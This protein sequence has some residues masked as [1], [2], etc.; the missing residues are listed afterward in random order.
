MLARARESAKPVHHLREG[1]TRMEWLLIVGLGVWVFLQSQSIATLKRNLATLER[2]VSELAPTPQPSTQPIPELLLTERVPVDSPPEPAPV[3]DEPLLLTQVVPPDDR[4]PLLLDT[5]LPDVSNDEDDT[6]K[7]LPPIA[8]PQRAAPPPRAAATKPDRR[9]EQWLAENGLA[10]LAGGAFALGAI[11]LVSFAAQQ[12]WFTP[13]VQIICAIALGL[14]LIGA[15]EWARRFSIAKP[16]GHPLAAALLAGAGVVALYVT[17]WASHGLYGYADATTALILLA[18]CAAILIGLSFLHG[19]ALGV[20]AVIMV[21]LAPALAG[22]VPWP[23]PALTLFVCTMAATGFGLAALRRWAWVA[24][25][26]L[27]GLYFWFASAIAEDEI[28]RALAVLSTASLGAALVALRQ[29]L[30]TTPE[31]RFSWD[32]LRSYAPSAAIAVSSVLLLWVWL[33]AVPLA[34]GRIAGPALIA[35]FHVALASYAVRA[36]LAH[37]WSLV[38]AIAASVLGVVFYLAAR[39]HF[40]PLGADVYPTIL[41]VSF[42]IVLCALTARP[43]RGGRVIVAGAGAIAAALLTALAAT[44]RLDWN[45]LAAWAPLI[46]GAMLLFAAAWRTEDEAQNVRKDAAIDL[47]AAAGVALALLAIESAV[48]GPARTAV[49]AGFALLLA[50]GHTWRGWRVLRPAALTAAAIAVAHTLSPALAGAS[51]SGAIPIWGALVIIGAAAALLFAAGYFLAEDEE[52]SPWSEAMTSAGVIAIIVGVFLLLRWIAAGGV[53]SGF[54]TLTEA[55]LRAVALMAAGHTLLPRA[56]QTLGPISRWRGH[57]FMGAG[58]LYAFAIAGIARNPWWGA[59]PAAVLGPPLLDTLTLAFAA[60]AALAFAASYRLYARDR[61]FARIYMGAGALMA[62]LWIALQLRRAFHGADMALGT[63]G[64]FEGACYGLLFLATALAIAAAARW[65]AAKNGDGALAL[66]LSRVMRIAAWGGVII[67]G[68]TLLLTRHPIWGLHDFSATDALETG[69]ATLTQAAALVLTL[70]L[71]RMLSVSREL[72]PARFAA[73]TASAL[74]AWSFGHSA[75][76]WIAQRGE[77]DNA[78]P[79]A[80]LEGF[81]HTLWPLTLIVGAAQLT[82]RAPG[83]DSVR[84]Y[85]NDLQ[86]IWATAIWPALLY[87]AYGLWLYFNP[88]RGAEAPSIA[89]PLALVVMLIVFAIAAGLS[90]AALRVPHARWSTQLRHAAIIGAIGHILIGATM[91]VRWLFHGADMSSAPAIDTEMWSYSATWAILGAA[92]FGLGMQRSEALLRWTGLSILIGT[93]VFV[94]YLTLTRLT[95]VAQFGSMLGLAV[96]LMGVA[97]LA[98]TY[99]PKNDPG[100]LLTITPSAR[101][102]RRRGRRQRTP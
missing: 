50:V 25:V 6:A 24:A 15:S 32:Q 55:S 10:W 1:G 45:A 94:F 98:R 52:R 41:A 62:F 68:M 9:F 16:P 80:G 70:Y 2:R 35:A 5:P 60:P 72:I 48:P 82:A 83:R 3:N 56:G 14:A 64:L 101:R 75:I 39:L 47:W 57:V 13:Q 102:E 53:G 23:T 31:A 51:L 28:R 61:L 97:W 8:E 20:L 84:A 79:M 74:F 12:D 22:R 67:G 73:A 100:D 18:L 69:L 81:A 30:A 46:T 40:G 63:V 85:L 95:G 37:Y 92:T 29:P 71:G 44:T 49:H 54:D 78:L 43:H 90:L 36:R 96:V 58:L 38:V 87:G 93:T 91:L 65:R 86:A 4:E 42:V 7:P 66:D 77:M 34:S 89:T 21:L 88:W 17:A 33:A 27:L 11:F 99:R 19:E 59:E 76:R 26:T